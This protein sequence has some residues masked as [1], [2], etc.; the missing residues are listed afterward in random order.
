MGADLAFKH[1]KNDRTKDVNYWVSFDEANLP[2][3]RHSQVHRSRFFNKAFLPT[4][5]HTICEPSKTCRCACHLP[6]PNN[7][8]TVTLNAHLAPAAQQAF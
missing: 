8:E 2:S 7:S 6:L 3:L 5:Y 1:L 4:G